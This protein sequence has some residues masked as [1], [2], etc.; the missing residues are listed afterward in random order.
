LLGVAPKGSIETLAVFPSL[1]NP[2]GVGPPQIEPVPTSVARSPDGALYVGELTGFP[3]EQGL[4]NIYRA[5]P[6]FT[7]TGAASQ[8]TP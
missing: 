4:A 3:F 2:T 5:V 1:P 7:L 6:C 8:A